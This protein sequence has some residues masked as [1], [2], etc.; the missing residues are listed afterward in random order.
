MINSA[1]MMP[2]ARIFGYKLRASE[3]AAT[4]IAIAAVV[5]GSMRNKESEGSL[6][7]VDEKT[8]A[9]N[10][11]YRYIFGRDCRVWTIAS[12]MANT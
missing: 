11:F 8:S 3:I 1:W 9:R 7:V 6:A 10:S 4:A 5:V 12:K 2:L